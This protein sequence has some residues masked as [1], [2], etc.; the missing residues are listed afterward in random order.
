MSGKQLERLQSIADEM[1][2]LE[3]KPNAVVRYDVMAGA[4]WWSDERRDFYNVEDHLCL[5][6]LF[7]YRT[8]VI[9][10]APEEVYQTFW[11]RGLQL[12]H[13]WPGFEPER[14]QPAQ[15]LKAF[16][17]RKHAEAIQSIAI[18]DI[19]FRI[20]NEFGGYPSCRTLL[21]AALKH[22]PPDITVQEIY[23]LLSRSLAIAGKPIPKDAWERVKTCIAGT[24]GISADGVQPETRVSS[25]L[26]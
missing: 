23:R 9:L 13:N 18:S 12:F 1:D 26:K 17:R 3:K 16:Y 21:T 4:L 25:T 20:K 8:S 15:G 14:R 10:E 11:D 19:A 5:R 24:L 6:P 2:R 7:R 22:D